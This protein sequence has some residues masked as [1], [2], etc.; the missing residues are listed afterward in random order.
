MPPTGIT[1]RLRL[2]TPA[3]V[4]GV[5][6]SGREITIIA[7]GSD[8]IMIATGANS[9]AVMDARAEVRADARDQ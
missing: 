3:V 4:V 5:T 1:L 8:I 6:A 9:T 7:I 2:S